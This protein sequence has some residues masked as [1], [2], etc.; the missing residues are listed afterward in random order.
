MSHIDQGSHEVVSETVEPAGHWCTGIPV[1][2]VQDDD[3]YED[4]HGC[5]RHYECQVDA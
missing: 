3:T 2:D 5:H 1:V 4:R